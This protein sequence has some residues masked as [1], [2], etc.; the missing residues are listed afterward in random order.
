MNSDGIEGNG[1]LAPVVSVSAK[2]LPVAPLAKE[3]PAPRLSSASTCSTLT[4]SCVPS[5]RLCDFQ[6]GRTYVDE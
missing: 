4:V 2:E 6:Y 1:L 3:P 5:E